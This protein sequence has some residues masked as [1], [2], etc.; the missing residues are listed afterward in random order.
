M[1]SGTIIRR[2]SVLR[3]H[4]TGGQR[5]ESGPMKR[6]MVCVLFA[7]VLAAPMQAHADSFQACTPPQ[8]MNN[9]GVPI[10]ERSP[11]RMDSSAE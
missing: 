1:T 11:L 9:F 10:A 5:K 2:E 6:L 4:S 3:A 8:H 7:A